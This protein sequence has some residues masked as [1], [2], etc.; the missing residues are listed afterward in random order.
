ME[1]TRIFKSSDAEN[2]AVKP[3]PPHSKINMF[4]FYVLQSLKDKNLYFGY[5]DDL[6]RRLKEHNDG[7]VSATKNRRPLECIYYEAYKAKKD[8]R[9]R[10]RQIKRRAK[11]HISL[12]RRMAHSISH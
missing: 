1:L 5:S 3:L 7:R 8:A 4:Y 12:K 9:E 10:E 6:R 2:Y 11:A